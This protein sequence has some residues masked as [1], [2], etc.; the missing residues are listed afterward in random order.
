MLDIHSLC[1]PREE[2]L[3][4]LVPNGG[5]AAIFRTFCCIGDSLTSGEF[6]G[7]DDAGKRGYHDMFEYSWGQFM[8][9][10]MGSEVRVFS[11]GGMTAREYTDSFAEA[12]GFWDADKACQAYIIAL[13]VN[14]VTEVIEHRGLPFG[15]IEDIKEDWHDNAATFAG[16]YGM[17]VQRM[18]EIQPDAKFFFMTTP[19]D[20][21]CTA[22]R[23]EWYRRHA[24]L[25]YQMA[26]KFE[27]A[28]V[29][30]LQKYAPDYDEEFRKKFFMSGHM[31]PCGYA[32][33]AEMIISYIDYIIR[34]NMEDFK[35]VG[36][37]GTPYRN[38]SVQSYMTGTQA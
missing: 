20:V 19:N 1:D 21:L 14:D 30:D 16:R 27:N 36:F 8:A 35:Q 33:T 4:R 18:K 2:P 25:L 13:G 17:I 26:E 23:K 38:M 12:N 11:R 29:L 3:D 32:F 22:E 37:I 28:Y 10:A 9:R 34:H 6:E 5:Y 31:S 24:E 7:L 15:S